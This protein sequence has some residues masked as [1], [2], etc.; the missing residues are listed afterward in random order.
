MFVI[1]TCAIC[2]VWGRELG[3]R[4]TIQRDALWSQELA[5]R[6]TF[7]DDFNR[8]SEVGA[9]LSASAPVISPPWS[10]PQF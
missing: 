2:Q 3:W 6:A 4:N 9:K 10:G 1:W 5:G 8:F 7:P